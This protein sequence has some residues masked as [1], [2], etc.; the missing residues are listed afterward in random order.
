MYFVNL[1][2]LFHFFSKRNPLK[3]IWNLNFCLWCGLKWFFFMAYISWWGNLNKGNKKN[4]TNTKTKRK[5]KNIGAYLCS[6]SKAQNPFLQNINIKH[7]HMFT[8]RHVYSVIIYNNKVLL[9]S[10]L[11]ILAD[12]LFRSFSSPALRVLWII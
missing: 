5:K 10:T 8:I 11:V 3:L 4:R 7:K 1:F 12:V 9:P 2:V 6:Y